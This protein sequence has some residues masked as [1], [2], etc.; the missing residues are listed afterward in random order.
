[1]VTVFDPKLPGL[2]KKPPSY[3]GGFFIVKSIRKWTNN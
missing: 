1:M 2:N 3:L